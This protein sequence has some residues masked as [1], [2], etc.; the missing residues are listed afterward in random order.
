MADAQEGIRTEQDNVSQE[1]AAS[2]LTEVEQIL[3]EEI[4][5]QPDVSATLESMQKQLAS[6]EEANAGLKAGISKVRQEKNDYRDSLNG[7]TSKIDGLYKAQSAKVEPPA[8][9]SKIAVQ[10]DDGDDGEAFIP[11]QTIEELIDEKI[12]QNLQP[13]HT[14]TE[15]LEQRAN[16][17]A[18]IK[19]HQTN[20]NK[21]LDSNP[22][23]KE[24]F[25]TIAEQSQLMESIVTDYTVK[26]DIK[27]GQGDMGTVLE[28]TDDPVIMKAFHDKYPGSDPSLVLQA[29]V[30][31]NPAQRWTKENARMIKMAL[32]KI[33]APST[34]SAPGKVSDLFGRPANMS[35]VTGSKPFE[36]M[37]SADKLEAMPIDDL[38]KLSMTNPEKYE[39]LTRGIG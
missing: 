19:T 35:T 3:T 30:A 8:K 29:M 16:Y 36:Q 12:R 15:R 11:S 28:I 38:L 34:N 31:S 21:L 23:F 25:S 1:V 32:K 26:N 39:E 27:I 20:F 4:Q 17:E 10:F 2:E 6:L 13:V 18:E 22:E 24:A 14:K 7:L 5:E 9:K 33:K 37:T